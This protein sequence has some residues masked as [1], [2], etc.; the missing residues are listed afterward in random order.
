MLVFNVCIAILPTE[1]HSCPVDMTLPLQRYNTTRLV[2][3]VADEDVTCTPQSGNSFDIGLTRVAC[4][5]QDEECQFTV[6]I[7]GWFTANRRVRVES[8][9]TKLL[10]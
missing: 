8:S 5:R 4:L 2:M 3:W 1:P 9:L 6:T 7:K 10:T